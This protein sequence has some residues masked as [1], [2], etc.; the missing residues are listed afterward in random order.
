MKIKKPFKRDNKEKS[1]LKKMF[2]L[3]KKPIFATIMLTIAIICFLVNAVI[4]EYSYDQEN[5]E[6]KF[7]NPESFC[8]SDNG[9]RAI[10]DD[11][12]SIYCTDGA[13]S[14]VYT[15]DVNE[16]P[17]E[18]AEIIDI[19]FDNDNKLYCHIAVYNEKAYLTDSES[20]WEINTKGE[21]VREIIHYDYSKSDNPP[22]H[23]VR[24]QGLH[25]YGEN[26]YYF[27]KEDDVSSIMEVNP[28]KPQQSNKVLIPKE[29][30]CE[31]VQCHS[32]SEGEFLVLKNNG[33]IGFISLEGEYEMLYKATYDAR[34]DEGIFTYDVFMLGDKLYMLAGQ[35]ELSLYEWDNEDW[36]MLL[37]I[38][39]SIQMSEDTDLYSF[40]LGENRGRLAINI[41]EA[42]Y[43]LNEGNSLTPYYM[44]CSFPFDVTVCMWLKEFLVPMGILCLI[45][46][47]F[48]GIGNLMKWRLSI[49]S[50]QMFS[51]IPMVCIM[52]VVVIT[53][54]FTS[55]ID[56]S[57]QD[58]IKEAI[59]INEIAATQFDGEELKDI[60]SYE[61]VDN[62]KVEEISNRLRNFVNG[63]KSAWSRNY[64]MSIFVRTSG[65]K[66][67]CV[68]ISDESNKFMA[69]NFSTEIPIDEAFYE[70]SNTFA[71]DVSYG[72][73]NNLHLV[74]ITP[75]YLEDGSYDAVM[76]LDASQDRLTQELKAAGVSL[77][78][79]ILLWGAL[80]ILVI[81]LVSAR[82][83][84][85]L[86]KAKDVVA[87]IAGGDFSVRV[88]K[89]SRDEVGEICVG[90]NDMADRLEEYFEEK[91]RNEQFYYKFVPEKFRELLNKEKFTDL[92]LGDAQSVDLS[93]L[94]CD[95]RA[96]SMNSE[97]M[98]AKENFDFVNRIYGK[99]G[100]I[101]RKHNG[102]VDKYIGD[103]V[104]AL[105]ESADDAVN[106][107]MELYKAIVLNPNAEEEFGISE[108]KVG[109]GIHSGMA[110]IGIV[111]EE[112]RMSGTV[113][114]NT[115]N[116][117]SR[118]E[119]LTKRYGA[120]MIISK[121]TLDRMDN[122]DM[123]STRY[124]GMVQVAGVNEVAGL[125]EVIDCLEDDERQ[126]KEQT[127]LTFREGVRLY[128]MGEL[129]NSLEIFK[130]LKE[131]DEED[132]ANKLY[133]D[134]IEDKLMCGDTEHNIFHFKRKN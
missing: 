104:M 72:D 60:T 88:D 87:Q 58:I 9:W 28:E 15:I 115:V 85:S 51:T 71:A 29:G 12:D 55:M 67:V 89:Y 59:A 61:S 34:S 102:F 96:F 116:L 63:N 105:F 130:K 120:G 1:K 129:E 134:Y 75:I 100:P 86:R 39:K 22:S 80:L 70:D 41:N 56:L 113:I 44:D 117:S 52:L 91:N 40:G 21:I 33:E 50:K 17:Y 30:F 36:N 76:L 119:A 69:N 82:N 27:Y 48:F 14:L 4:P 11:R 65:E 131:M 83:V 6:V 78:I 107:G 121:D 23:I 62:G 42:L 53:I 110:R 66:F 103:A 73:E 47:I 106:A 77:L 35:K 122:P 74:L 13:D 133:V 7:V 118:I 32:T 132:K 8:T 127:N 24:L 46:G 31:I 38:K 111:G 93:I 94:F 3:L 25:F 114:A 54:M 128:H 57:S 43:I 37:S 126:K 81:T 79:N 64:S 20:V 112:E 5:G 98:T 19:T 123:L 124:L 2:R 45:I 16:F 84:K 26:I 101:I 95:I 109:I 10:V 125:Y 18:N 99:A 90:V 92:A 49:L 97:M 68:A 108:V